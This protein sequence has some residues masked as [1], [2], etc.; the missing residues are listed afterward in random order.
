MAPKTCAP[1]LVGMIDTDYNVKV[2]PQIFRNVIRN[3]VNKGCVARKKSF[4]CQINKRK[5]LDFAKAHI[6]KGNYF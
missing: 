6:N 2:V 5:N 4:N 1:K 3:T